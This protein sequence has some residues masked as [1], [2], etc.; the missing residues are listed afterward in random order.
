MGWPDA[1][2]GVHVST[3]YEVDT[4][5]LDL[6]CRCQMGWP[7][8]YSAGE[9]FRPSLTGK[10]PTKKRTYVKPKIK[11]QFSKDMPCAKLTPH[12]DIAR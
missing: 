1:Y 2:V 8:A 9:L 3:I 6:R 5:L 11:T 4:M 7:D 12:L 10:N